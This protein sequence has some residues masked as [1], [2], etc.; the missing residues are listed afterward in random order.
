MEIGIRGRRLVL[1]PNILAM[2]EEMRDYYTAQDTA[3][4]SLLEVLE[5]CVD[6]RYLYYQQVERR[7]GWTESPPYAHSV[8]VLSPE[9]ISS[10]ASNATLSGGRVTPPSGLLAMSDGSAS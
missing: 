6:N 4:W 3:Q 10:A 8:G 5:L 7:D 9:V 1:H 2:L